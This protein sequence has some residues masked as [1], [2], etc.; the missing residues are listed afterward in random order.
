MRIWDILFSIFVL[1]PVVTGGL[2]YKGDN[3][4][5]EYTQPGPAAVILAAWLWWAVKKGKNPTQE[6][7]FCRLG[8]L[9][10]NRWIESIQ[11]RPLI[12]LI[13][14]CIFVSS[15]WFTTSL[16][17][18]QGFGSGMADLGIFVNGIWNVHQQGFPYSSIKGGASLLADH[19]N[20]LL[21]P[22]GWIFFIWPSPLFLLAIQSIALAAG[23][24]AVFLL[25]KQRFG[26][27]DSLIAFLPLAYW[28]GSPIRNVNRF[29]FHPE[30]LMLPLF[31]FGVFFLQ[32]KALPRRL[33]GALLFL[34]AIASKESAG[35]V[36]VGLGLAW[37]LGAGPS[38]TR[39]FTRILGIWV[40][41]AGVTAFYVDSQVIPK[42]FGKTYA[43]S[44]LYAPFGTSLSD[45]IMAPF[46]HASDF[47]GRIVSPSRLKFLVGTILPFGGI[48]LFTPLALISSL[49]GFLM[50]FLTQGDHRISL[51]YH[52]VV[53]PLIGLLM[54]LPTALE[55]EFI[56]RHS[57]RIFFVLVLGA[58]LSFGRSEVYFWRVYN[59][60]EHLA[61]LRDDIIPLVKKD[62][63]VSSSYALTPHL[64]TRRW[65]HQLPILVD[66]TGQFVECAIW[67][68]SVNNTP[69]GL[70]DE[71]KLAAD[72]LM[73]GYIRE[74]SCGSL[75]IYK[76]S[77]IPSCLTGAPPSCVE[78]Q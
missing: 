70:A 73:G 78:L 72:L 21:Y 13:M 54:V 18:H 19:Q 77:D 32:E 30:T 47:F 49:P 51:S 31:L 6:S 60:D 53:E 58:V 14:G 28:L 22:L 36:A 8:V 69:M 57:S 63:S 9:A 43:Y 35:P 7:L 17:R 75:A 62:V 74:L 27:V 29:D 45:L 61:Y 76:R 3:F 55:R 42:L 24:I 59:I 12:S 71:S 4:R 33:L 44:D 25:L 10:W 46:S 26:R 11:R 68:R 34:L 50:L 1:A 64:A 39:K 56:S 66:E 20:F 52:Y 5:L 15:I 23:A 41:V 2:W 65:I 67:E 40:A 48:P 38:A 16:L 37:I